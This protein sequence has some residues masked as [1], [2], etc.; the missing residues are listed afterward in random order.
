MSRPAPF[1]FRH[2]AQ[3]PAHDRRTG[4]DHA[5]F[6]H[7]GGQVPVAESVGDVPP[8]A[9]FDG[10]CRELPTAVDGIADQRSS[11]KDARSKGESPYMALDAPEPSCT[12]RSPDLW[13]V[14]AGGTTAMAAVRAR[15][16]LRW[17]CYCAASACARPVVRWRMSGMQRTLI[18]GAAPETI[19][20]LGKASPRSIAADPGTRL[21]SIPRPCTVSEA[22]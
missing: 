1:V 16:T 2:V 22:W 4:Y 17:V 19:V 13:K 3:D 10:F 12:H 9:L 5:L 14:S 15:V 11:H 8:D 21:K 18:W 20:T 6:G 7:H